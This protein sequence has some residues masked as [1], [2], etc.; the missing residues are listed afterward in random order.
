MILRLKNK[1]FKKVSRD[2]EICDAFS[3]SANRTH[4]VDFTN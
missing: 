4:C 2:A 1:G 3:V